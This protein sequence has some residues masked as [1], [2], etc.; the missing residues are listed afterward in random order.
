MTKKLD[1]ILQR[2]EFSKKKRIN[3]RQ[4]GNAFERKMVHRLN[5]RFETK[6]FART[7]GSGAFATTHQNLPEHLKI[8]GDLISPQDFKFVIECK[9]GYT[10]EFDDP[11]KKN[12][13]LQDFINQAKRDADLAE[14]DWMVIY[15][16]T[17][18]TTIVIV[19]KSYPVHR[20]MEI[21]GEYFVYPLEDFLRLENSHF[22]QESQA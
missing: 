17:R 3:S 2:G 10:V 11:F 18:R 6:E 22:F 8:H 9:S 1:D 19:G 14:K 15:K 7:P 20:R 13:E 16:K 21:N 12:S 5:E 4:K